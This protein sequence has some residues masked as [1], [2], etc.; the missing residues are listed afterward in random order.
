MR[1]ARPSH[2]CPSTSRRCELPASSA[3]IDAAARWSTPFADDHVAHVT[4]DTLTHAREGRSTPNATCHGT[5]GQPAR[6][7]IAPGKRP[8]IVASSRTE[9]LTRR[10][11]ARFVAM[12]DQYN[13]LAGEEEREMIPLCLDE[14]G[15][16]IIWSPL[17][18][19]RLARPW[20][21][22]KSTARAETNGVL[23]G[24]VLQP[25]HGRQ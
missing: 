4:R 20:A 8:H 10:L 24:P 15:G 13:L 7:T 6:P 22:A 16:T 11:H 2:W 18:R 23:C 21:A 19:G 12:P 5:A 25:L 1:S 14:G 17:A 3:L 9:A